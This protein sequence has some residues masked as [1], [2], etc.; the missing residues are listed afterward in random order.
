MQGVSQ[1]GVSAAVYF[2]KDSAFL[3]NANYQALEKLAYR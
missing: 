1:P 2:A 3:N